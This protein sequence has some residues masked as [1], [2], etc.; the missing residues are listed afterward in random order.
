M[1]ARPRKLAPLQL[2]LEAMKR[3]VNRRVLSIQHDL[4]LTRAH[5]LANVAREILA[6]S[7]RPE[8]PVS[9]HVF[10]GTPR[11]YKGLPD[12]KIPHEGGTFVTPVK[13]AAMSY[14]DDHHWLDS[15]SEQGKLFN[16]MLMG[17]EVH[18]PKGIVEG[19][20]KP[21]IINAFMHGR[22]NRAKVDYPSYIANAED[23]LVPVK[24]PEGR[25]RR[26]IQRLQD[27]VAKD[28]DLAASKTLNDRNDPSGYWRS[29]FRGSR[30]RSKVPFHPNS[31]W[32][33]VEF[34]DGRSQTPELTHH[35]RALAAKMI[36][37]GIELSSRAKAKLSVRSARE[38]AEIAA[39]DRL[40][41]SLWFGAPLAESAMSRVAKGRIL[42]ITK[43][44]P[45]LS[46]ADV[47]WYESLIRKEDQWRKMRRAFASLTPSD[48]TGQM[49]LPFKHSLRPILDQLGRQE[50]ELSSL[51]TTW[52]EEARPDTFKTI[53]EVAPGRILSFLADNLREAI[54]RSLNS[55]LPF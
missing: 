55:D 29:L 5:K 19:H 22:G 35:S 1:P 47:S 7:S 20:G 14:R 31:E 15:S 43:H 18:V 9:L 25:L 11:K 49:R 52:G 12:P 17:K 3:P 28:L 50:V 26:V 8:Y 41:K 53:Q 40:N 10:H 13:R 34:P 39:M 42:K 24:S 46:D 21:G 30:S 33:S 6:R 32:T 27:D 44:M 23:M 48:R 16:L 4:P 54:K 38:L 36:G 51:P 45:G 2:L 37:E